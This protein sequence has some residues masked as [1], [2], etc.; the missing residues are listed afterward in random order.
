MPQA[1]GLRNLIRS[2]LIGEIH[3]INFGGQH[4]LMLDTR[5]AWYFEPGKHGGTINDIAIH[6]VDAIP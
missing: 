5:A 6:A 1:I 3:A 4:P 2:G